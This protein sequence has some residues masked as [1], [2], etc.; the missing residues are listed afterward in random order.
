[1]TMFDLAEVREFTANLGAEMTRC[2]NG[3][4][5]E[6]ATVAAVL[7]SYADICSAFCEKI[8]QWGRDVFAGRVAF[9]QKVEQL[10]RAEGLRLYSRALEMASYGVKIETPSYVLIAQL[11][12][13]S[14]TFRFASPAQK[15]GHP[16]A[17]GRAFR[18]ADEIGPGLPPEN[19]GANR[20]VT[21]SAAPLAAR[22]RIAE[23]NVSKNAC[24]ELIIV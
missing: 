14:R 2:D 8:R 17:G 16:Q 20:A 10:W 12:L 4:G 3:E 19:A 1:M 15:L 24:I 13:Q 9:D 11:F 22:F 21:P 6:S 23:I 7:H 5:M 18:A